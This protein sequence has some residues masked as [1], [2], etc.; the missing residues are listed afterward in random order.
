MDSLAACLVEETSIRNASN[1]EKED[2]VKRKNAK[3]ETQL[4]ELRAEQQEEKKERV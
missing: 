4:M 2:E 3:L 1:R